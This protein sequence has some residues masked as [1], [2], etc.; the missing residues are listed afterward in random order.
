VL[1]AVGG[2]LAA[3]A[4]A[5]G[6]VTGHQSASP[7]RITLSRS[8]A[9]IDAFVGISGTGF[10]KDETV[11]IYFGSSKIATAKAGRTGKFGPVRITV[12]VSATPGRH[13]M[14]ARGLRPKLSATV[15]L[16]VPADGADWPQSRFGPDQDGYN[17]AE[18]RIS[19]ADASLLHLQ[20]K[21]AA[22]NG[23]VNQ[24]DVDQAS[25]VEGG[26]VYV[27][28]Y[29]TEAGGWIQAVKTA[30]GKAATF[31]QPDGSLP[32]GFP[33]PALD[34]GSLY[35]AVGG[36]LYDDSITPGATLWRAL[37]DGLEPYNYGASAATVAGSVVYF[38]TE[39]GDVHA[40]D[41]TAGAIQW[42][43]DAGESVEYSSPAVADG[44]VYAGD[45]ND[46]LYALNA[47]TG[48]SVWTF[49]ASG[50][51]VTDPAVA[52]GNVYVGSADD[53]VYALNATTGQELWHYSVG[54]GIYSSV[55][56]AKGVV[57]APSQDG[58]LCALNAS[59]GARIWKLNLGTGSLDS[60]TGSLDS[61]AVANGVV[62]VG[63]ANKK[64][65]A[66]DAADGK[67][68]W[69]YTTGGVVNGSPVIADGQ[70]FVGSDDGYLYAFDLK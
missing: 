31:Y 22:A 43:F 64:I 20:W 56:V 18:N 36:Y 55:A 10:G 1:T 38:G 65:Y 11:R 25:V 59:T 27:S 47:A 15:W 14:S 57:Y 34:N 5:S 24:T 67:V 8:T 41:A 37:T 39:G 35:Y 9:T 19:P 7:A 52:N 29:V 21:Y 23:L 17:P 70:L 61:P 6:A 16:T 44:N 49:T 32:N 4:P 51:I 53:N 62:Y 42:T 3:A 26:R 50:P 63:S 12:P 54:S 13:R 45:L 33:T 48:A 28:P 69:S 2:L 60:G 30:T 68:L 40:V 58:F 46:N 66:I